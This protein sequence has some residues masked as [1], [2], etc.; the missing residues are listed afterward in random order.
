MDNNLNVQGLLMQDQRCRVSPQLIV[1][2]R[3][4]NHD[5]YAQIYTHYRRPLYDFLH[6]LT[7]SHETAED[8]T[9]NVFIVLWE[10]RKKLDQTQGIRRYLFTVAKNMAMRYFRLKKV[11]DNHFKYM[12]LH[13][14]QEMAPEELLMSKEADLLVDVAI[15]RM[16]STRRNIFVMYYKSGLDYTQIAD[17]MGMNK[18]TVANHLSQAKNDIRQMFKIT[19]NNL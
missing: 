5:A 14:I 12:W 17:K 8:I 7:R 15:S 11:E 18:A 1:A 3:H 2:L 16:P 6:K 19:A 9:H 10:N 13:V 4:G